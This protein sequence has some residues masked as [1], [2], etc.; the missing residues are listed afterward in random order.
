MLCQ[1]R[2]TTGY[3]EKGKQTVLHD[4]IINVQQSYFQKNRFI[5][6]LAM[7]GPHSQFR[8]SSN[9]STKN[10]TRPGEGYVVKDLK[11]E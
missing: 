10:S 6:R 2:E 1:R 4:S 7:P 5:N 9:I 8:I 11:N 3:K